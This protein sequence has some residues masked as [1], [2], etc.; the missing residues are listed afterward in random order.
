MTLGRRM[1]WQA[2]AFA[3]VMAAGVWALSCHGKSG[4]D[5]GRRA[6]EVAH[7]DSVRR[8]VTK[9][10]DSV[11]AVMAPVLEGLIRE[12]AAVR[13]EARKARIGAAAAAG[14]ARRAERAFADLPKAVLD[15]TP[16]EVVAVLDSMA[17][18]SEALRSSVDRLAEQTVV[19][20]AGRDSA[21][22]E[23]KRWAALQVRTRAALDT[24]GKEIRQLRAQKRPPKCGFKCGFVA[25]V[26]TVGAA[27]TTILAVGR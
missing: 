23:A 26:L 16:P 6:A 19:L 25:A 24:A 20:Q 17:K 8:A 11:H 18:A 4:Y 9:A 5:Q 10:V 14:R 15:S 1:A 3:A 27:I 21:L 12:N 22:A 2:A 7:T 13:E